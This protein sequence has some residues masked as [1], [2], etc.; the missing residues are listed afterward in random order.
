MIVYC[1]KMSDGWTKSIRQCQEVAW[2][3]YSHPAFPWDMRKRRRT[4]R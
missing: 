1:Y 4:A 2:I 3:T